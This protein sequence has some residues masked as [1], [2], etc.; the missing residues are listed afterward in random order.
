MQAFAEIILSYS[1]YFEIVGNIK[2]E[3]LNK[4]ILFDDFTDDILN[5]SSVWDYMFELKKINQIE[6]LQ[7]YYITILSYHLKSKNSK[8]NKLELCKRVWIT[9]LDNKKLYKDSEENSFPNYYY[10]LEDKCQ[11]LAI[12]TKIYDKIKDFREEI[13]NKQNKL[14][15]SG[16]KGRRFFKLY[17]SIYDFKL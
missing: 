10:L 15:D 2:F 4:W 5:S 7:K 13:L 17:I 9:Y 8:D 12:T 16:D 14:V 11:K 6:S 1:N 3:T